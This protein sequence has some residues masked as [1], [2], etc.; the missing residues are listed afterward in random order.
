MIMRTAT[1]SD[2]LMFDSLSDDTQEMIRRLVRSGYLGTPFHVQ[3]LLEDEYERGFEN[4]FVVGEQSAK[5]KLE[6]ELEQILCGKC[7]D[8]V[9]DAS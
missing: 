1:I 9:S 3:E 4:G 6:D 2:E 7:F 8:A 5:D